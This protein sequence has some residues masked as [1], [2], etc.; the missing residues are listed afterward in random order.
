MSS[1]GV[2]T[3]LDE[4]VMV[5][6]EGGGGGEDGVEPPQDPRA[7]QQTAI[8]RRI[9]SKVSETDAFRNPTES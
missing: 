3:P 6:P 9:A 4:I 1:F 5:G 8:A 2:A 7:T